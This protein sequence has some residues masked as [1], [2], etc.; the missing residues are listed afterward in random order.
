[1]TSVYIV[2]D[3]ASVL[4]SLATTL[5]KEGYA[6]E[7]FHTP[8]AFMSRV[9]VAP[10][11]VAI[12]DIFFG[13]GE[14]TG[15]EMVSAV[16]EVS[17]LTQCLI[18]SG[19]S[20]LQKTLACM[21]NGA[22]DFLEKPVSL[23]R[24]LTTVRNA[25]GIHAVRADAESRHRILGN[26]PSMV[27]LR[28]RVRKLSALSESVLICGENGTG[29]ELVAE[30]LHLMS[31]RSINP[32][33]KINCTALNPNLI[34]SELFG[35]KAG[36]FTGADRDK[37]GCFERAHRSSLF[38]DEIGDLHASLQSKILR[39]L[40]EKRVLPVG[41]TR[42]VEI[43]TRLIFA[44]H[45]DLEAMVHQGAFREDLYFRISTFVV[46][47]PPLRERVDDI[48]V[49]AP[50]YLQ[51]FLSENGLPAKAFASAAIDKMKSYHYPGNVRELA[52][53]VKNAAFFCAGDIIEAEDVDLSP[54]FGHADIWFRTRGLTLADA[55][56]FF[57]RELIARRLEESGNSVAQAAETLGMIK[58]NLYRKLKQCGLSIPESQSER[59]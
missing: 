42:E 13:E 16:H 55:R 40:Q 59:M 44:T 15:D 39:V 51:E 34:E 54:A 3:D 30:N 37:Q 14:R 26:V 28:N 29:K 11:A 57:E 45:R 8:T 35:H 43:D 9:K 17:P 5:R 27:E 58:N 22:L 6:I 33:L 24:L 19:E 4:E 50:F 38:L 12:L 7:T 20:D 47:I 41:G 18:I 2:D 52:K 25:S 48:D 46:R 10:P 56:D 21:K 23:P 36:S 53:I 1:M 31:P 49:L 32:F